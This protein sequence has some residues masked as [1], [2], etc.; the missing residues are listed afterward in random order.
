MGGRWRMQRGRGF[1]PLA[2]HHHHRHPPTH[3]PT[4][5]QVGSRPENKGKLIVTIFA[6]NGER[7]LST[8]LYE[9]I[10]R[11]SRAQQFEPY[12]RCASGWAAAPGG[13]LHGWRQW[14]SVQCENILRIEP[15]Y[16]MCR[17]CRS[18]ST[19]CAGA[20]ADC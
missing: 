6:S 12:P 14:V 3:P 4:Q 7:Y 17:L 20:W 16:K 19:C 15:R 11:E 9:D 1:Q 5:L 13:G 18:Q 8:A 2:H 10:Y